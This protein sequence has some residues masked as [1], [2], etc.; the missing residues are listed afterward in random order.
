MRIYNKV[1]PYLLVAAG[2][3]CT[4]CEQDYSDVIV[5]KKDNKV[6]LDRNNDGY[7][8]VYI[9]YSVM[10]TISNIWF[11]SMR[12]GDTLHYAV[13]PSFDKIAIPSTRVYH[14]YLNDNDF[15]DL[16]NE[17]RNNKVRNKLQRFKNR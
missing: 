9:K 16:H 3:V 5:S 2:F 11:K 6:Y 1:L 14:K 7:A 10:D 17:Y 12:P 13:F 15:F 4:G 8:D